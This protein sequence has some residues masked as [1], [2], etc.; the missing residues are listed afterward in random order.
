MVFLCN[1]K[2]C[3]I[4]TVITIIFV[5]AAIAATIY[6]VLKKLHMLDNQL[7]GEGYWPEEDS[8]KADAAAENGVRYTTDQDFV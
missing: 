4:W 8:Q 5:V 1:K 3:P 7:I 6:I 2:C